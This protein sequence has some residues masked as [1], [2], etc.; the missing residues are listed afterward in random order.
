MKYCQHLVLLFMIVL[1]T[2]VS[3]VVGGDSVNDTD[4][5]YLVSLREINTDNQLSNHRCGGAYIGNGMILTAAHCLTKTPIE[6]MVA[7]IGGSG[8][9]GENNCYRLQQ[10][11]SHPEYNPVTSYA[12]LGL[13][14][15][16]SA[17]YHYPIAPLITAQQDSLIE[18]DDVMQILGL[19]STS[20]DRYQPSSKL[21]GAK[22]YIIDQPTCA[23]RIVGNSQTPKLN[24]PSDLVVS[25]FLCAGG[26]YRGPG[27]G[28]SG[29]P[30][31]VSSDQ[32]WRY[33]AL[34][35]SGYH[36]VGLFTR[37]GS[38]LDW[39]AETVAQRSTKGGLQFEKNTYWQ[40]DAQQATAQ[41]TQYG[42]FVLSNN[43]DQP[44]Q[45]QIALAQDSPFTI[46][47]HNCEQLAPQQDCTV[48]L[49]FNFASQDRL[50]SELLITQD[51]GVLRTA[52]LTAL[53]LHPLQTSVNWQSNWK[54]AGESN[55]Q[56]SGHDGLHIASD[57]ANHQLLTN[58]LTGPLN[59]T[60]SAHVQTLSGTG[61]LQV[62]L[63]EQ[64]IYQFSGQC[65]AQ[66]LVVNIPNGK[67]RVQFEYLGSSN[68][69]RIEHIALYDLHITQQS[70]AD[71]SIACQF[72][73]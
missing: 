22:V 52:T 31:F 14:Q 41:T 61:S 13:Y 58:T 34:V 56:P 10:S 7:C 70:L 66:S 33:A 40:F 18:P 63:D 59:L 24:A 54:E 28:D 37:L 50:S 55:W 57:S 47:T 27:P 67:H 5:P 12:D 6:K 71:G 43:S 9:T 4:W 23:N 32:G 30:A 42:T 60:F 26:Q 73:Q 16:Q 48:A 15:M 35:S 45:Q 25:E 64:L 46:A 17:P 20:Y 2:S 65:D 29:T 68:V 36:Y 1:S 39:I 8:L 53:R 3:A 38:H 72:N 62:R 44:L 69:E 49:A 51:N 11:I 21:Q 19:G